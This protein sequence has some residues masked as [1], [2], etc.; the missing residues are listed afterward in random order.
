MK[1]IC[2]CGHSWD[3]H[4]HSFILNFDALKKNKQEFRNIDGMLGEECEA[5]QFEGIFTPDVKITHRDGKVEHRRYKKMCKCN[6][7]WDKKW[8]VTC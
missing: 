5:T 7:Y 3:D 1:K 8:S 6:S 2:I 4:H